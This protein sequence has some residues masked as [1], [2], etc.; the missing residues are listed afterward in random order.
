M[1]SQSSTCIAGLFAEWD[2]AAIAWFVVA[3]YV[4][5][6]KG[7][8]FSIAIGQ[9]PIAKRFELLPFSANGNSASAVVFI[10]SIC[11]A[12]A[13]GFH[14]LPYTVKP[15]SFVCSCHTMLEAGLA[16][17][18][19]MLVLRFA[20]ARFEASAIGRATFPEVISVDHPSFSTLALT[21]PKCS[22]SAFFGVT[23]FVRTYDSPMAKSLIC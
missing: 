18:R 12:A 8:F 5:A 2:V 20:V 11:K 23:D 13:A 3:V 14:A 17:L 22:L 9:R 21:E 15:V 1:D 7:Q 10:C 4:I 6:L 16:K 19:V